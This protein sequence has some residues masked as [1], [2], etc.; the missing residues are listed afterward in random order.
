MLALVAPYAWPIARFFADGLTA[1]NPDPLPASAVRVHAH[2]VAKSAQ[3]PDDPDLV[4][5]LLGPDAPL[6]GLLP[7]YEHREPHLQMLLP[8]AQIQPPAGNLLAQPAPPP[9]TPPP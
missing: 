4:A 1:P 7:G 5:A 9:P 3:P 2:H 8:A 6:A